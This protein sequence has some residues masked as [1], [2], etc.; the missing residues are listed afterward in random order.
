LSKGLLLE[1]SKRIYPQWLKNATAYHS[2][3]Q[4][5]VADEFSTMSPKT[6]KTFAYIILLLSVGLSFSPPVFAQPSGRATVIVKI[7]GLHSEKG[8]VK[9]AVFNSSETWLGDH[10][11]YKS[12]IDVEGQAVVWKINDVAYGD[13]GIAVFHDENKNGKMDKNFLGIPQEAYGFSNNMRV[14]LGPPKWEKSKF[15]VKGPTIEVSI[16]VK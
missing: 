11:V 8:Q 13:Y 12:T 3:S 1:I 10:P 4:A 5:D 14:A 16:E 6:R 15:V 7:T 9:I 2:K